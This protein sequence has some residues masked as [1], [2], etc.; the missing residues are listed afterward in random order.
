MDGWMDGWM[1]GEYNVNMCLSISSVTAVTVTRAD[2]PV[3]SD[4]SW[5]IV[6][7]KQSGFY[8]V[9][10]EEKNWLAIIKQLEKDH[11]VSRI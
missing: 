8:R 5:V 2:I 10:Y 7:V 6:N 4:D 9:N 3:N 1:D 11:T